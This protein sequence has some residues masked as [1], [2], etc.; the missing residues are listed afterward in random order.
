MASFEIHGYRLRP[1]EYRRV[2]AS[3]RRGEAFLV[4]GHDGG[5]SYVNKR[6]EKFDPARKVQV[7]YIFNDRYPETTVERTDLPGR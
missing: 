3:G 7:D 4:V 6:N 1:G 2:S 5:C